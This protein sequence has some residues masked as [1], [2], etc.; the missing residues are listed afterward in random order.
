MGK[1]RKHALTPLSESLL[2]VPDVGPQ[3]APDEANSEA[4]IL[5]NLVI[6]T[7]R[8]MIGQPIEELVAGLRKFVT[9]ISKSTTLRLQ[10]ALAVVTFASAVIVL[11][12]YGP[13]AGWDVPDLVADGGTALGAGVMKALDLQ[14]EYAADLNKQG[15]SVRHKF[16]VLGSDALAGDTD[17]VEEAT[18]RVHALEKGSGFTLLPFAVGDEAD[19]E[20][21]SRLSS[22][23]KALRLRQVEDFITFFDWLRLSLERTS[24]TRA[25]ESVSPPDPM[26]REG[27]DVGWATFK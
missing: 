3:G 15:T 10:V 1:P 21:L 18:A 26:K 12:R 23:R 25:G 19:L 4:R 8:S 7:S 22:K 11:K 6:D 14:D 9:D 2:S 16:I 24:R 13:V 20:L 5:I 17:V 27:N